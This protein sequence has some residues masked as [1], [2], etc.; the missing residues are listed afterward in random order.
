M[1]LKNAVH[2]SFVII[3]ILLMSIAVGY[4]YSLLGH[5]ADLNNHPREY[6]EYVEK[7]AAEYG[8]PEYIV[9]A[10]ILEESGF[11]SNCLSENGR[12]GLMQ[13]SDEA[14]Y[15]ISDLLG[16]NS[17]SG[18]LYDPETNVKYGTYYLSYL[19]TEY[20]R[21]KNVF[22]AYLTSTDEYT[23]WIS[24]KANTDTSGNL[25][26]IPDKTVSGKIDKIEGSAELYKELYY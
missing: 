11:Q 23:A 22:A 10:V 6:T 2:R 17:E 9:Y 25:I 13:L 21:W 12:V 3:V 15:K 18:I 24:D 1:K 8:I 14:F 4:V 7:Y 16:E 5:R 20:S 19:Y 26:K